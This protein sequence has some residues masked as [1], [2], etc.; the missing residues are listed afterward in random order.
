MRLLVTGSSGFVGRALCLEAATRGLTVLAASRSCIDFLAA[1]GCV[2][3]GEIDGS[4]DW[5]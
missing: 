2:S 3:V 5:A 4:T 1:F